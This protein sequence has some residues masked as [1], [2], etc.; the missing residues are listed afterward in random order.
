METQQPIPI[1]SVF[2]IAGRNENALTKSFGVVLRRDRTLLSHFL[3]RVLGKP[4]RLHSA[5]FAKTSFR[6]ERSHEEGRVDI[7]ICL[8]GKL[9]VFIESKIGT[10]QVG[11]HQAERYARVLERSICRMKCFV[12]LTQIGGLEISD[13]LKRRFPSIMFRSMGWQ[14]SLELLQRRKNIN[15]NLVDEYQSYLMD[16]RKMKIHD[17]DIWAVA[18]RG[19]QIEN[20][21]SHAIYLHSKRHSP[22]FIGKRE[23]DR[24]MHRVVVRVLKPV[25]KVHDKEST[26]GRQK[27]GLYVYELGEALVLNQPIVNRFSQRSAISIPFEKLA[28]KSDE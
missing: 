13:E 12:F 7:E 26:L 25:L 5:D 11:M 18:V 27:G 10:A 24:S 28:V 8:D 19:K 2:D 22:V 14:E 20:F 16:A 23:W 3:Q 9:H 15:V 21:D 17:I 6:F 4:F 1:R